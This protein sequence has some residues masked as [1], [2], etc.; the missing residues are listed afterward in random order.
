MPQGRLKLYGYVKAKK[1]TLSL[2]TWME[3]N[4]IQRTFRLPAVKPVKRATTITRSRDKP[5]DNR[6][7]YYLYIHFFADLEPTARA[8]GILLFDISCGRS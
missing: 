3:M 7:G 1:G 2:E 8:R 4:S 6:K 5:E